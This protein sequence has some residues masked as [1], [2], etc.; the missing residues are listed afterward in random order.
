MKWRAEKRK[1]NNSGS[2]EKGEKWS[3][4]DLARGIYNRDTEKLGHRADVGLCS[5]TG[6]Q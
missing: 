2:K 6:G 1:K 5:R 4:V 3:S